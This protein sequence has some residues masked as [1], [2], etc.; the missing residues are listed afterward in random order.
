MW[1]GRRGG[2]VATEGGGMWERL[3]GSLPLDWDTKGPSVPDHLCSPCWLCEN[4]TED[5]GGS[6]KGV[7]LWPV[8]SCVRLLVIFRA[9]SML[10]GAPRTSTMVTWPGSQMGSILGK[11][12]EGTTESGFAQPLSLVTALCLPAPGLSFSGP[13]RE[14][15]SQLGPLEAADLL[16]CTLLCI[17]L[18]G[19]GKQIA[20]SKLLKP[21]LVIAALE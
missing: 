3:R 8:G 13:R 10:H 2:A 6:E 18:C 12:K 15:T 21:Q 14:G 11:G 16:I 20:P 19:L 17:F 7:P 4:Q 9:L 1:R 5:P